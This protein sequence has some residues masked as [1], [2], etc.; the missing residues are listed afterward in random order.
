AQGVCDTE[1]PAAIRQAA[2]AAIERGINSYTR[3]DGLKQL[4]EVI[5]NKLRDHNGIDADPETDITVSAGSTG[6]L[7][8]ACMALLNPG[9]GV[10]LFEPYYGYH[11]NTLLAVGAV[12]L[13]VS[14]QPPN[15]EFAVEDL[16]RAAARARAIVVNTPANPSGKV[17]S[18]AELEEIAEVADRFDL[19]VLTDEIYEYFVY[20]GHQHVSPATLPGMGERTVTISSFSKVFSITGWRI[21]YSVARAAWAQMIGYINDLVYVCAPAPLQ[22]GVAVGMGELE[23]RLFSQLAAQY[24]DKRDRICRALQ[25]AGLSPY[26]PQGAYYVLADA[27]CL[28]GGT[29]KGK[30]MALLAETGVA[31]VPG[32]AFWHDTAGERYLRFCFAKT[33]EELN[34][35]CLRLTRLS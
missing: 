17:L 7:Y 23:P 6:A 15:W 5:A 26:V 10:V 12:P 27:T 1:V 25:R 28:P 29:S 2:S 24:A 30:A 33:D 18:R 31:S 4:R 11:L 21:G 9:D 22:Y 20:D 35:A 14:L 3:F 32:S 34:E 19:V 13:Y 8:C 16:K